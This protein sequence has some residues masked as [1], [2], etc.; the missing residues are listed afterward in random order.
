MIHLVDILGNALAF[1]FAVGV[2]IVAH[3]WGH[4]VMAKR[5]GV[6]VEEFSVGFGP[7][8]RCLGHSRETTFNLRAL[9]VGGFVRMAGMEPG[10]DA[11][12][13]YNT[14]PMWTRSKIIVAGVVVNLILGFLIFVVLGVTVGLP[15]ENRATV[16]VGPVGR[17]SAAERAGLREGDRFTAVNGAP[18]TDRPMLT[19][20]I[21]SSAGKTVT[22]TL[23]RQGQTLT[24]S[25]V[26]TAVDEGGTKIG[27]LG[28]EVLS[29][30]LWEPQTLVSSV[31][32][33]ATRTWTMATGIIRMVFSKAMFTRGQVGGPIAI[34]QAAGQTA[35]H[36]ARDFAFF[37][38]IL[39]INLGVLNVLPIPALDGGHLLLLGVEAVRRRKLQANTA[40]WI[41]GIGFALLLLFIF[42][43]TGGDLLRILHKG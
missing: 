35:R 30:P 36:G 25:A 20:V 28:F 39:S 41:Q 33:G 29:D 8:V 5:G 37:I 19:D 16:S 13:G 4:Y 23:L 9:P 14:K 32:G 15:S 22:L 42:F 17:G 31:T 34:A 3:E 2:L 27:R 24:L 10:D 21:R 12:D 38:A 6:P 11:P 7:V 26:P 18:V 1:L 40:M 43:A